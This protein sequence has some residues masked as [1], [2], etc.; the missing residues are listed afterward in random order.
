MGIICS[1][2]F[3]SSARINTGC[4]AAVVSANIPKAG[5]NPQ[6]ASTRAATAAPQ[7][8]EKP[9]TSFNPQP[10]S[11]RAATAQH[12]PWVDFKAVSILSPHQHGLQRIPYTFTVSAERV[13]IL[14][15]HQH[16][17]Q[18][19]LFSVPNDDPRVSILS[20]HQHGLQLADVNPRV[21]VPASFN[22]QPASTRAATGVCQPHGQRPHRFNPQPASTRAAT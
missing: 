14:S 13:S 5:F 4:N 22:P 12:Y 3:Q 15:P 18:R 6:P 17:L 11:T 20:P 8:G 1:A 2:W 21:A 16:G 10:A 9:L 19:D 7:I